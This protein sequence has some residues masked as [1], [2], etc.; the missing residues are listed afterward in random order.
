MYLH[1][2]NEEALDPTKLGYQHI[3]L[4]PPRVWKA[5]Y[6]EQPPFEPNATHRHPSTEAAKLTSRAKPAPLK[7]ILAPPTVPAPAPTSSSVAPAPAPPATN[8]APIAPTPVAAAP[9]AP[10]LPAPA[11]YAHVSALSTSGDAAEALI[12]ALARRLPTKTAAEVE[13]IVKRVR[14][15]QRKFPLDEERVKQSLIQDGIAE[16][17]N[18]DL[19]DYAADFADEWRS[20]ETLSLMAP[21]TSTRPLSTT[22]TGLTTAPHPLPLPLPSLPTSIPAPRAPS[23]VPA[24]KIVNPRPDDENATRNADDNRSPVKKKSKMDSPPHV[25]DSHETK[26]DAGSQTGSSTSTQG[27]WRGYPNSTS[28]GNVGRAQEQ[29]VFGYQGRRHDGRVDVNPPLRQQRDGDR[30]SH[31][32]GQTTQNNN[33]T[34]QQQSS[35]QNPP[36]QH[37]NNGRNSNGSSNGYNNDNGGN[38]NNNG[39]SNNGNNNSNNNGNF[40]HYNSNDGVNSNS[41]GSNGNNY[42]G[43]QNG[44]YNGPRDGGNGHNGG[45]SGVFNGSHNSSGNGNGGGGSYSGGSHS[46][47]GSGNSNNQGSR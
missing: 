42:N 23:V 40:G 36:Y 30:V 22:S 20:A 11:P 2:S 8:H 14:R 4:L 31:G 34:Y 43:P 24:P 15:T 45:T 21:P 32:G 25:T 41:N 7:A 37:N 26:S 13:D 19:M 12:K 27:A 10:V 28:T 17:P 6:Y 9:P 38:N 35:H 46:R 29:A 47:D 39:N 5:G 44:G 18:L 16:G 33:N 1:L 3:V